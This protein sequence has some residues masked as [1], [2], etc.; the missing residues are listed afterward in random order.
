M[1]VFS[2][3]AFSSSF[4]CAWKWQRATEQ[5]TH[6]KEYKRDAVLSLKLLLIIKIWVLNRTQS[7]SVYRFNL[8]HFRKVNFPLKS[9]IF[10][11]SFHF[12]LSIVSS[13]HWFYSSV[14]LIQFH[15]LFSFH[16]FIP[17]PQIS[18]DTHRHTIFGIQ[19][20]IYIFEHEIDSIFT[21]NWT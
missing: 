4:G 13:C 3:S 12:S 8:M 6:A 21:V 17:Q 19:F 18:F 14:R 16:T 2:P 20:N 11:F 10:L 7:F 1:A 15:P 5:K 9:H